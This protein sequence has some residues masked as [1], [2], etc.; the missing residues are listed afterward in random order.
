MFDKMAYTKPKVALMLGLF[1]FIILAINSVFS[2]Y[3]FEYVNVTT[4]VNVTNA[5]P[6]VDYV[7]IDSNILLN[8]GSFKVVLCNVS[9]HDWNGYSDI[10]NVNASFWDN[11]SV[12]FSSPDDNNTHYTNSSCVNVSQSGYYANYTCKF[13][14]WYY[15]NNGS[16]WVYN[17]TVIDKYNFT[18]TGQNKTSI[19]AYYALNVTSLIDFGDMA[20]GDYKNNVSANVTNFGNYNINISVDG[21]GAVN[22]DGLAMKCDIRNI[23]LPNLKYSLNETDWLSLPGGSALTDSPVNMSGLTVPKRVTD[24]VWNQ[25][26]WHLYVPPT[27]NPFGVCN[28]T[29]V[30]TAWTAG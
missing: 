10:A 6:E 17:A 23:T 9:L 28:G 13:N 24:V 1:I 18:A 12:N 8:A 16:N 2:A 11:N 5:R 26:Y 22:G 4:R 3:N 20:V 14:V 25:T 21:Y 19:Q 15:A 7:K 30:F 27:E 29:V